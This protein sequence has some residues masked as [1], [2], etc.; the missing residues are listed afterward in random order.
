MKSIARLI[1]AAL[2][3]LA[4]SVHADEKVLNLYSAC[5]Y[6][7]DEVLYVNFT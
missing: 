6:Q 2:A 1:F 7:I 5:Y 3:P 4:L